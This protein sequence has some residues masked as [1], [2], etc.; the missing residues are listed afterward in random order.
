MVETMTRDSSPFPI[1][2]PLAAGLERVMDHWRGLRRGEAAIRERLFQPFTT[3]KAAGMGVGLSLCRS[4]IDAHGGE[5]WAEDGP[6]GGTV[7]RF[8]LPIESPG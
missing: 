2:A 7:F 4:I 6:S 1:D 3:T 8:T 5:I